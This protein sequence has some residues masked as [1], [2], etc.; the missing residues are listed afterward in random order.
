L[1]AS[2]QLAPEERRAQD[3][4]RSLPAADPDPVF[5]ARL[6]REFASATI[7]APRRPAAMPRAARTWLGWGALA[8]AAALIVVFV[9]TR[10]PA[11]RLVGVEGD[12]IAILDGRPV[13]LAHTEE[14]ARRL[15]PGLRIRVPDGATLEI[16]S[17][18]TMDV[19]MLS[20]ADFTVPR[21]PALGWSK[22]TSCELRGGELRI[23]TGER[24]RGTRMAIETPAAAIEVTGTTLAVICDPE[25]TCVCVLEGRVRVGPKGGDMASVAHGMR[26]FVFNDARAPESAKMRE[27]ERVPLREL[28]ESF[29][30][31][32]GA[33]PR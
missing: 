5:L 19:R 33:R 30:V 3:A 22:R 4:V 25:G 31:S 17:A 15:Q 29:R 14:L 24:F 9:L 6:A 16:A 26:R 23:T 13:P 28:H 11:W 21:L 7:P 8:A 20:G 12:G 18:G 10:P 32:A 1:T 2:E 27:E